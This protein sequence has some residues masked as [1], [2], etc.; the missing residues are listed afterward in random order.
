[1]GSICDFLKEEIRDFV[2][3][4]DESLRWFSRQAD[5]DY[6]T[7]YRLSS[8]EQKRLSFLNAYRILKVISPAGYLGVLGDFYPD[9]VREIAGTSPASIDKR[10]AIAEAV[11]KDLLTFKVYTYAS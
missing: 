7:I 9:E 10:A 4:K 5:V 6:T 8:G 11:L 3:Q 2:S 1:M